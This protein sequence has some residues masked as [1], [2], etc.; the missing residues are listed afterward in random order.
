MID[1]RIL[2]LGICPL[3]AAARVSHA[4]PPQPSKVRSAI[5][6]ANR[7]FERGDFEEAAHVYASLPPTP[8]RSAAVCY[9]EGLTHAALG[10][11]E[12][13]KQS[14][15]MA[16]LNADEG[17][18]RADARFNLG[19]L[20]YDEAIALAQEEPKLA[21]QGLREAARVYRSV[22]NVRSDDLE[23]AKNVERCRLAIRAIEDRLRQ[24]AEDRAKQS[25][26]L[27][28]LSQRLNELAE[29]QEQA[30][31][32]SR[33]AQEQMDQDSSI[34]AEASRQ[35]REQQEALSQETRDM[36]SQLMQQLRQTPGD[37]PGQT[38]MSE[39]MAEIEQAMR[40]QAGA[41][42]NLERAQ[43]G[44]AAP[45]QEDAAEELGEA[46]ERL[47]AAAQEQRGEGH[48]SGEPQ[49]SDGADP[50]GESEPSEGSETKEAPARPREVDRLGDQ[51]GDPIA[52]R[53]L[54]KEIRDRAN[55]IRRGPPLPTDKDW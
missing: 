34:G 13:A 26:Q 37:A 17:S 19:R 32:Q 50:Q 29:R 3:L 12:R 42:Q 2:I 44:R 47:A 5:R 49:P 8:D 46:A 53:Y 16:D 23:A 30:S 51:D 52:R 35:S 27:Q 20:E 25:E 54:E 14:F 41:E 40:N 11:I 36:L 38:E 43:P 33:G 39:A 4:E 31:A 45:K 21:M 15:R 18:I 22:L 1:K 24:E 55:R 9:N 28:Q 48:D 7:A 10:D 6:A